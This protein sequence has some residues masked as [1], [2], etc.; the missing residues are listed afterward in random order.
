MNLQSVEWR[1]VRVEPEGYAEVGDVLLAALALVGEKLRAGAALAKC[2]ESA[3]QLL[4]VRLR[5]ARSALLLSNP[6]QGS[7][8]VEAAYGISPN[9]L[10]PRHGVGV[11]GRVAESGKPIVVPMVCQEPMALEEQADPSAW[12]NEQ[13]SLVSVPI[14][15]RG[16]C[17]GALSVYFDRDASTTFA[18]RL[19]VVQ[20]AAAA[21]A[22][23]LRVAHAQVPSASGREPRERT[24]FEYANM[25]GTSAPMRQIYEEIGQ[26]A[27]T[28]ATALILGESGTGK[29][30]VAQAIHANS[31]RAKGPFIKI[32]GAA[33]PETLFESELFGHER[34]AFTG[35]VARKKGR[36]D[37]AQGGSI[38]L[39][40]V[41]DLPLSTQVKLLRVLQFREYER[42]GG[43]ETLK[44][45]V[46]LIAAT[47]KSMALAVAGGSFR[48]DLYYR[49]N[50]FN[51]TLPPLRERLGDVPALAEYFLEKYARE[52]RRNIRRIGSGALDLMCG[53]AW[54]GNVRELENAMERSVVACDGLVVEA[55][56]LPETIRSVGPAKA[57]T[58]LTLTRAVE[59]LERQMIQN[60]L[61]ESVGNL[62]R[63]AR[64]LGITERILRYKVDKYDLAALH[65]RPASRRKAQLG[66]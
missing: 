56:H 19:R 37:L 28:T 34:G 14:S 51:I 11:A 22:H 21:V 9:A 38:F 7:L 46:R 40:E 17:V 13:L 8:D 48:E 4:H 26:V 45:D 33:L 31:D 58:R 44:A 54:P 43:T 66:S 24:V 42:L 20:G 29:E 10:R 25:I 61:R 50:V 65:A 47:N 15:V 23:G 35:A 12:P 2:F 53:Y 18:V 30:L 1:A 63:A 52:H 39:D 49:L 16:R 5:V 59:E 32:S 57:S 60:A 3:M 64:S 6:D 62:A 55:R 27:P 36:L 41:G